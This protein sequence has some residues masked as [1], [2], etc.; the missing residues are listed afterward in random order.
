MTK[1]KELIK[2][3]ANAVSP[4]KCKDDGKESNFPVGIKYHDKT[5]LGQILFE[6][7]TRVGKA[8]DTG[9]KSYTANQELVEVLFRT[10]FLLFI[11]SFLFN[12]FTGF[13]G[14]SVT[15]NLLNPVTIFC[16]LIFLFCIV[17][18]A[19][20]EFAS[21]RHK[22]EIITHQ[23]LY[24]IYDYPVSRSKSKKLDRIRNLYLEYLDRAPNSKTDAESKKNKDSSVSAVES[25][26]INTL[27]SSVLASEDIIDTSMKQ[28]LKF[29]L[30]K[31]DPSDRKQNIDNLKKLS[32]DAKRAIA[33]A[34]KEEDLNQKKQIL[35]EAIKSLN[36][37]KGV[38]SNLPIDQAIWNLRINEL[39]A[40]LSQAVQVKS[41]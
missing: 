7:V 27:L 19:R 21:T 1:V 24:E 25:E 30:D 12:F 22:L 10:C 31:L 37:I 36:A 5:Q 20:E 33:G 16:Y 23:A 8:E 32:S 13:F 15:S 41:R 18:L 14:Y 35:R 2:I 40:I 3:E 4:L 38:A 17:D 28:D 6:S 34:I 11:A 39:I 9:I 29:T 26:R